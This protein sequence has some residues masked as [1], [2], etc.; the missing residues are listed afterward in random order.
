MTRPTESPANPPGEAAAVSPEEERLAQLRKQIWELEERV[1]IAKELEKAQ[2]EPPYPNVT[3]SA[4]D[5]FRESW[6]YAR[7]TA[8]SLYFA[9]EDAA[10]GKQLI[11]KRRECRRLYETAVRDKMV[12]AQ[13]RLEGAKRQLNEGSDPWLRAGCFGA[14][15]GLLMWAFFRSYAW[16][17]G[18]GLSAALSFIF[19]VREK[20]SREIAAAQ[21]ELAEQRKEA[22]LNPDWF[23]AAEEA[24]GER[25]EILPT[26][27]E[28]TS[29]EKAPPEPS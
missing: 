29:F 24:S 22:T 8:R 3:A 9:L 1:G 23:N 7:R 27:S 13:T 2:R 25:D 11:G 18:F 17:V 4:E 10:V 28:T 5:S 15:I 16:G 6:D 19:A 21:N 20:R 26:K 12:R 14:V